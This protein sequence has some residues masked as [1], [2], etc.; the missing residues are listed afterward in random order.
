MYFYFEIF[1]NT[2]CFEDVLPW[3]DR[4]S[5]PSLPEFHVFFVMSDSTLRKGVRVKVGVC[6][7]KAFQD[8]FPM[9]EI[10]MIVL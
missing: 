1:I 8:F 7:P 2:A 4:S 5:L 9:G 6:F 3:N 10:I